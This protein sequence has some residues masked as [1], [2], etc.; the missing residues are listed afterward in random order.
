MAVELPVERDP[1]PAD[2]PVESGT[3]F[4]YNWDAY[5]YKKVIQDFADAFRMR[6]VSVSATPVNTCPCPEALCSEQ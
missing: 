1:I 2:T 4:L 5:L 3:L 6:S